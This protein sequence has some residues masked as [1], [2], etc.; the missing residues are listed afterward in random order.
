M[1]APTQGASSANWGQV[2]SPFGHGHDQDVRI[3][4]GLML[5]LVAGLTTSVA[6]ATPTGSATATAAPSA[7]SA[8][9]A[10]LT[11]SLS[12]ELRCGQPSS[13]AIAVSLP[14]AWRVPSTVARKAVWID[15]AHP[16][17]VTV[18][19]HTLSLR[20]A[21]PPGGCTV[22]APGTIT[23]KFTRAAKLG[24]PRK[25]G[26]YTVRASIG[27]QTFSARVRIKPA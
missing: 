7:A 12:L 13:A 22:I 4:L 23:V 20:P 25:A 14:R 6:S 16:H 9:P 26:R 19:G 1:G 15:T 5:A 3:V 8:R 24:N 2:S 11:V 27:T 21:A 18:S 10:R 17:A